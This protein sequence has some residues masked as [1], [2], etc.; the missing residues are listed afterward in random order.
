MRNA[1]KDRYAVP[2]FTLLITV[3]FVLCSCDDSAK[4]KLLRE[5]IERLS[6]QNEQVR[7]NIDLQHSYF[8]GM[9]YEHAPDEQLQK[10]FATFKELY[11]TSDTFLEEISKAKKSGSF[12]ASIFKAY[13]NLQHKFQKLTT[14]RTTYKILADSNQFMNLNEADF[15]S[16]YAAY[17]DAL[18]IHNQ[19]L[20]L[21]TDVLM[22][23]NAFLKC[24]ISSNEWLTCRFP[25]TVAIPDKTVYKNGDK[26]HVTAM[27]AEFIQN[28][29]DEAVIDGQKVLPKNGVYTYSRN[30]SESPGEYTIR[31]EIKSYKGERQLTYPGIVKYKVE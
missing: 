3:L 7:E 23:L 12:P 16:E 20:L 26:L 30:V 13:Q 15:R 17:T 19:L 5:N 22:N 8:E 6:W 14:V 4:D 18:L 25:G 21:E 11:Q 24:A 9:T 31:V 10:E 28:Y 29:R 2:K 27:L 1:F